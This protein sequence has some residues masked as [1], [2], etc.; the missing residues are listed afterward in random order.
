VAQTRWIGEALYCASTKAAT[1]LTA[2]RNPCYVEQPKGLRL[3]Y[4]WRGDGVAVA[5]SQG[6]RALRMDEP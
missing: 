3:R 1:L 6:A 2:E 5:S 4:V